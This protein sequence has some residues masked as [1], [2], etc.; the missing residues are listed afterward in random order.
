MNRRILSLALPN[1]VSNITVPLLGMVDLAIVGHY[2][3]DVLIGAMAIGT[4]VFNLIYWNFGFLRMGT[5]GFTAQACGARDLAESVRVLVR[6]L[7]VALGVA[8]LILVLQVPLLKG[9]MW[10]M[11]GGPEVKA[12]A[13]DYFRARVWAAPA[14]LG[15]YV[16]MG[17]FIGMQNARTPMAVSIA[18]NLVNIGCSLLFVAVFGLGIAG[19]AWGTVA[20]QW[21]GLA[22]AALVWGLRYRRLGRYLSVPDL[23]AALRPAPMLRFFAVN[24]D[25]FLRTVCLVAVFTF[26]TSASSGMGDTILAVNA[27]LLQLFTLFSYIMDGF[28]HAGEALVGRYAGAGSRTL[29]VRCVRYLIA[30]GAGI[31]LIFTVLYLSALTPVLSVFGPSRTVLQEAG[32]YRW[33]VAAVPLAGFLAFIYDGVLIGAIRTRL[34]RDCMFAATAVFFGLYYALT[35]IWGNEALW[36]AFVVYLLLRGVLQMAFSARGLLSRRP[37]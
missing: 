1:I 24:R 36:T 21:S 9:A 12:A 30:W 27:L 8:V 6:G 35:G 33:W 2:G 29:L 37:I 15:L 31:A 19:V 10:L 13:S 32:A 26:F 34:M 17:W 14:T 3:G 18:V 11:E 22:L 4:A 23:R 5:S 7:A 25:I 16:F 20:A 28:A